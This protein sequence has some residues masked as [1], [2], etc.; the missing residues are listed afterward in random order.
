[1]SAE[2]RIEQEQPNDAAS[3]QDLASLVHGPGR[4]A[5]T[6]YRIREGTSP[7][8]DLSL[9]IKRG[10]GLVGSVRFTRVAVDGE[11]GALLLGPLAVH[12]DH[13]GCGFGRALIEAGLERA[14]AAGFRLVLLVGD[15]AY[16]QRVGFSRVPVGQIA[17]PGPVDPA[18]LLAA[19]LVPD[20]LAQFRGRVQGI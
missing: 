13:A 12:P 7:V 9:V 5:R 10:D 15:L 14:K 2:I 19:E 3:V 1:M 11:E 4:F 16:Y 17:L 8:P 20:A 6:A 18:R